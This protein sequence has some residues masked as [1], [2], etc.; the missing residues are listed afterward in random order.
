MGISVKEILR[1]DTLV[2]DTSLQ[3]QQKII[4]TTS[5]DVMKWFSSNEFIPCLKTV[6]VLKENRFVLNFN[7]KT[8]TR[9]LIF[10]KKRTSNKYMYVCKSPLVHS[11]LS[12]NSKFVFL[13]NPRSKS[14]NKYLANK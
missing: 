12:T 9:I 10:K 2:V 6:E 14:R 5:N 11:K 3:Q 7:S 1:N 13:K 4:S 8:G